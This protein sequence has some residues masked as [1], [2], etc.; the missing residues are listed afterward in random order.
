MR[1]GA[2]ALPVTADKGGSLVVERA[3]GTAL[4]LAASKRCSKGAIDQCRYCSKRC[5]AKP[6]TLL[7]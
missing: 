1:T 5:H 2:E 7:P 4:A 6:L 3:T